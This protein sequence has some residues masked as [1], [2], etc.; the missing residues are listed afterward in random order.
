MVLQIL[1]LVLVIMY[2]YVFNS[3]YI[4]AFNSCTY[5]IFSHL[6]EFFCYFIS[7]I[8]ENEQMKYPL[9][10]FLYVI[11]LLYSLHISKTHFASLYIF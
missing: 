1:R 6:T 9:E 8:G 4:I 7:F 2:F 5:S 3:E 11:I 10:I